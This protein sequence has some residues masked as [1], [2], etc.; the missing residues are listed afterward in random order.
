MKLSNKIVKWQ[1]VIIGEFIPSEY[2]HR[3][4][5]VR[6]QMLEIYCFLFC[7]FYVNEARQ[8]SFWLMILRTQ[9]L[10][11]NSSGN[12]VASFS[13]HL[14]WIT[15]EGWLVIDMYYCEEETIKCRIT[16]Q[17]SWYW[18]E[19]KILSSR[20]RTIIFYWKSILPSKIWY[21]SNNCVAHIFCL[22]EAALH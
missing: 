6:K 13:W 20:I 14:T 22:I 10:C 12:E 4:V 1:S 5:S 21:N 18:K 11:H 2:L 3:C 17:C 19:S 7:S 15:K 8:C 9:F 16:K